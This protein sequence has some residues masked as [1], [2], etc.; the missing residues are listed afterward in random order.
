MA[1]DVIEAIEGD[2]V[3]DPADFS[4]ILGARPVGAVR[5]SVRR[6]GALQEVSTETVDRKTLG[7]A[8][9]P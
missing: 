8:P 9:A 5:L 3:V 2:E 4:R 6:G 7:Q 1:G